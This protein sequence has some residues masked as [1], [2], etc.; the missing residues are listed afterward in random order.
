MIIYRTYY[1]YMYLYTK[2]CIKYF[3]TNRTDIPD[4]KYTSSDK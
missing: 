3:Y 2:L 4:M 1:M